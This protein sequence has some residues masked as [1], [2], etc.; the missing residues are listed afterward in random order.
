MVNVYWAD[1]CQINK[2]MS[3]RM[4][5][6]SFIITK[7]WLGLSFKYDSARWQSALDFF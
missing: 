3:E 7:Y 5:K 4:P 1:V 2:V 6:C